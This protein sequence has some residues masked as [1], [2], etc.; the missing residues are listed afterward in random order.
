MCTVPVLLRRL[1]FNFV[2]C[3]WVVVRSLGVSI[4][5]LDV[6]VVSLFDRAMCVFIGDGDFEYVCVCVCVL[7]LFSGS[8]V[9]AGH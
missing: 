8:A 1:S 4:T 3:A 5:D 9:L 7:F 2:G 6:D